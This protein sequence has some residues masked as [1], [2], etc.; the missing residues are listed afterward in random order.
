MPAGTVLFS[1]RAP[2]G[3]IAIAENEVSTNQGFKS[4]IPDKGLPTEYLFQFLKQ[5]AVKIESVA[6]GSTFKE[7]SGSAL[8][9]IPVIVPSK[10]ILEEL[11]KRT[12]EFNS[13]LLVNQKQPKTL[14]NFVI[15]YYHN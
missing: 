5:N 10:S 3:Y 9:S 4:L 14:P 8:K 15:L 13:H 6:S 1:S 7:V 2:I 12:K 11:I